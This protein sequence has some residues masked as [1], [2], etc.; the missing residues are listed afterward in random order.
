MKA[1]LR[2][3][4]VFLPFPF[5]ILS[6]IILTNSCS[7]PLPTKTDFLLTIVG[8]VTDY[9]TELPIEGANLKLYV[10]TI[11]NVDEV[12][13]TATTNSN[14]DYKLT[15]KHN[16]ERIP[17]VFVDPDGYQT[18]NVMVHCKEETQTVNFALKPWPAA[19]L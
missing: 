19:T 7:D 3:P 12:L 17:Q 5:L 18:G 2:K 14:G 6:I 11:H 9:E 13:S 10:T 8:K 4:R 15:G 1:R 16:C